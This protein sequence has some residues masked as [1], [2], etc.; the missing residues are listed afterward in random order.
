[1]IYRPKHQMAL[2]QVRRAL[3][4]RIRFAWLTFDE[5]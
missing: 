2:G 4:N 1:V 3:A 5:G